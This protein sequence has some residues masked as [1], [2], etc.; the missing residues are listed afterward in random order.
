MR[1]IDALLPA[2]RSAANLA[3]YNLSPRA[4]SSGDRV[5][6]SEAIGRA[7]DSRRARQTPRAG[8]PMRSCALLAAVSAARSPPSP[9]ARTTASRPGTQ[10]FLREDH[11]VAGADAEVRARSRDRPRRQ[12]LHHGDV[13]RPHRALR[14]QDPE[15]Q[16][17][18]P[19]RGHAPARAHGRFLGQGLVHRQRQ[20]RDRRAR[21][22]DRQGDRAPPALGGSPHTL[23]TD[24][25]GTIWFTSQSGY[26]GRLERPSGKI[27]EYRM[28]GGPYGIALDKLGKVWVCRMGARQDG[29]H[30]R[31]DG[32]GQR[33]LHGPG[34]HA[35]PR[36]GRPRRHASG[37]RST[38]SARSRTSI[39]PRPRS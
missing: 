33:A 11:R 14:H 15:I 24:G 21:P 13:R 37:S 5:M 9:A 32:Q 28:S 4:R 22:G 31:Q 1:L 34:N 35:A 7:F 10:R 19:S 2:A 29:D 26:V 8:F 23:V 39:R 25:A 16:R 6:A 38:A 12:H 30:R 36:R 27:T 17:V 3:V 20:G 18:E